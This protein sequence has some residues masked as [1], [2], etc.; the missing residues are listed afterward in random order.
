MNRATLKIDAIRQHQVF[1]RDSGQCWGAYFIVF[2]AIVNGD[3]S[4]NESCCTL[5]DKGIFAIHKI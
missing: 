1:G 4:S 3:E 5:L 2:L